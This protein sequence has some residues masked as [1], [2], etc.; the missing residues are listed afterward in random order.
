MSTLF[1]DN[2]EFFCKH[3]LFYLT[4]FFPCMLAV[5][6]YSPTFLSSPLSVTIPPFGF[7]VS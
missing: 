7:I 5:I 6:V 1:N 3:D 2:S 4:C